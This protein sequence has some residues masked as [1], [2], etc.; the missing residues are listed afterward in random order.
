MEVLGSRYQLLGELGQG[1]MGIVHEAIDRQLERHVAIKMILEPVLDRTA[2]ERFLREA[3]SAAAISHPNICQVHEIG[4]HNGQPF[5]VMELLQG[6][7]LAARIARGPLP[8]A[9]GV[10]TMRSVLSALGALHTKGL[11]H[12]D[13]KPSNIFLTPHGVKLLDFGL[14]R[15]ASATE[16][17][18]QADL[19]KP[20]SAIGT[21][22]YMAP[23]QIAGDPVDA[24]TDLWAAGIVL[25][26]MLTGR[27]PFKADSAMGMLHAVLREPRDPIGST[28]HPEVD[29]VIDRVLQ[30]EPAKRYQSAEAMAAA[31]ARGYQ[32]PTAEF[33]PPRIRLVVLPFRPLRADEETAFLEAALPDAITTSL[34][35]VSS[36]TVR[37]NLAALRFG[38]TVDL[39]KLAN[40]L[41][42]N[43]VLTGTLL[44]AGERLRVTCQLVEAPGGNLVWSETTERPLGDL[45]ELQDAISRH[46]VDALPIEH[47]TRTRERRDIPASARAYELYLRANALS[48]EGQGWL[49]SRDLYQQCLAEDPNFAPAWARLGRMHRII[50]KY[51]ETDHRPSFAAAEEAFRRAFAINPDLSMA[52]HLFV[53]LEVE[54]GHAD[55]A[56]VHLVERIKR[57][58]FQAE[59]YAALCQAA[60]YCGLLDVSAAAGEKALRLDPQVQTSLINTYMALGNSKR[61]IE[62]WNGDST[63]QVAMALL[64]T[65][66]NIEDVR[67]AILTEGRAFG[68]GTP[69]ALF[70]EALA[71]VLGGDREN[72]VRMFLRLQSMSENFPDGEAM[73]QVARML[74]R[75]EAKE[76]ALD[77]MSRAVELGYYPIAW[78]EQDPW[79]ASIRS[80]PV[81]E[82][83]CVRARER[84][85]A[86]ASAF[87]AAGGHR[88]LD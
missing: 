45:F 51:L 52:H 88:L 31:L 84:H 73:Y 25:Y 39:P 63:S 12:R 23:E 75:V 53:Y 28:G 48:K 14:A 68:E 82:Q 78:F 55:R 49:L 29:V 8:A 50:G 60:R 27:L 42:V 33:K 36:L 66:A 38:T 62:V 77:L 70:A 74:A 40:E 7:A 71:S 58:P 64:E 41:D 56:L 86:A 44:R 20:G 17:A 80:E 34:A 13:L 37:S 11:I 69:S 61:A 35:S 3:R 76:M 15:S 46:I 16:S 1:G 54:M 22:R 85:L 87:A 81:Y 59:L 57:A 5:L 9:E 30:R 4:E 2:R 67:R 79:L 47:G 18:T 83:T 24:R 72:A 26:E 32:E 21:L 19:T 43:H 10:S 6:E 65:G